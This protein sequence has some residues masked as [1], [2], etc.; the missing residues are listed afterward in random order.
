MESQTEVY[1]TKANATERSPAFLPEVP[2]S[3]SA[4]TGIL[5]A[6]WHQTDACGPASVYASWLSRDNTERRAPS[7]ASDD[8][9]E[10]DGASGGT[11][12]AGIET[13]APPVRNGL[14]ES[15][16]GQKSDRSAQRVW[17]RG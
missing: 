17:C 2:S 3:K 7:G 8:F 11:P 1:A 16:P 12:R 4:R 13:A 6:L 14:Y 9:R 5:S 15:C 10:H